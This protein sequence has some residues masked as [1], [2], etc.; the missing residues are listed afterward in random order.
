MI[1][2]AKRSKRSATAC[3]P[4]WHAGFVA[5]LPE[6]LRQLRFTFRGWRAEE[7]ADA[8]AECTANVAVAFARLYELG[9]TSVAYPSVLARFAVAQFRS[10]RRVGCQLNIN[11]VMA[12]HAQQ[13]HGIHV[14]SLD[15]GESS[16]EWKEML[17]ESRK[18]T[19]AEL[20]ASRIDFRD[21]LERMPPKKR[22]VATALATGESTN[23]A[24]RRFRVTPGRIS[25]LRREF[26]DA[27]RDF[28]GGAATLNA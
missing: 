6:I 15:S 11:D 21:W 16:R 28:H 24:A 23:S 10:G 26:E 2:F 27:W 25:Q 22:R 14:T 12:R 19:P 8:I 17:A 7:K 3:E 1:A 9:K 5:M 13:H 18:C 4:A 20:A